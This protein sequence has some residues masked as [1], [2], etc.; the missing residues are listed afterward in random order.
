MII[1][2]TVEM[3]IKHIEWC[4]LLGLSLFWMSAC[5][6]D[7]GNYDYSEVNEITVS[8][9][10]STYQIAAGEVLTIK[11][12]INASK[13]DA[14]DTGKF[15]YEWY[16]LP[17][18]LLPSDYSLLSKTV[19][20]SS[21]SFSKPVNLSP[22]AYYLYYTIT[23]T[24]TGIFTR[25]RFRL[26][27]TSD[28][29]EGYLVLCDVNGTPR[30]DM[31]SYK[32]ATGS[33]L[34]YTDIL[35]RMGSTLTLSGKAIKVYCYPY[36]NPPYGIYIFT[37]QGSERVNPENFG[38]S[39]TYNLS[40]DF[41]T[42]V[43]EKI[44]GENMIGT[45]S[46]IPGYVWLYANG[47]VYYAWRGFVTELFGTTANAYAGGSTFKV[48]PYIVVDQSSISP[49]AVMYNLEKKGFVSNG[50]NP[51]STDM[52]T[53]NPLFNFQTGMDLT[54]ME[55]NYSGYINAIL[56]DTNSDKYY[57]AKFTFNGT[58]SYW[59]ELT[60]TDIGKATHFAVSPQLGYLFYSVGGKVYEYDLSSKQS[61]LMVDKGA[62]EITFLNF[63]YFFNRTVASKASTYAV[64]ANWLNVGVY[65]SGK[66]AESTGTLEMY[67]VPPSNAQLVKQK[68]YD[69]LGKIVSVSYRE[70]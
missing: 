21:R 2:N 31:L 33:T 23:D 27:V 44:I 14:A 64:W 16:S 51:Y 46:L 8:G 56:H 42:A 38:Y 4:A 24:A 57:F 36:L 45:P 60:G 48:S 5:N 28:V 3:K 10:D 37:S 66:P 50:H 20:D 35:K 53:K 70:R 49:S 62:S 43:N 22:G 25:T 40:Y 65:D 63:N 47:N 34:V 58:Q 54:Y 11:P 17:A 55:W 6:K 9:V 1:F 41:I 29:Y 13:L 61:I 39:L 18:D 30:L 19:L 15:T 32:S 68:S 69:G 26:E 52:T 59:A 7:Y 12:T 67:N